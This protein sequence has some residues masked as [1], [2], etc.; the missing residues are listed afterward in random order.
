MPEVGMYFGDLGIPVTPRCGDHTTIEC[1][2]V[3]HG[4]LIEVSP[5]AF[6]SR[7]FEEGRE[8]SQVQ[9]ENETPQSP[10]GRLI[11]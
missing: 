2:Q 3:L 7:S 6:H 1:G 9:T 5:E 8:P 4:K 10:S 11:L